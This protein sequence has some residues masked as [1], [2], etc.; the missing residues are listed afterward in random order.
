[1]LIFVLEF[2]FHGRNCYVT[3]A[4]LIKNTIF[5]QIIQ[6]P[7]NAQENATYYIEQT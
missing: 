2:N 5:F 4:I 7:E 3:G 1:M 6:S